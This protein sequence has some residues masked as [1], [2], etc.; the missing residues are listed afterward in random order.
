[1]EAVETRFRVM[2]SAAHVVVT[3]G[4]RGDLSRAEAT[5]RRLERLWS[6][7]LPDS[8]VSLL[9][10]ARGAAVKV[11]P[12]TVRLFETA[13]EGWS[14]TAGLFDPT[15]LPSVWSLGYRQSLDAGDNRVEALVDARMA[16]GFDAI[17]LDAR[18]STIRMAR[19]VGFDPG[20][21]G[22]GLAA[23]MA[24]EELMTSGAAGALVGVGGDL[25]TAGADP[26][27]DGWSV[28][29][30]DPSE[31][32]ADI[33]TLVLQEGGGVATS[34]AGHRR[35]MDA[36]DPVRHVIEPVTGLVADTDAESVTVV[37]ASA[38][39]AEVAATGALVAGVDQ[40]SELIARLGLE[41]VVVDSS[42]GVHY[43]PGLAVPA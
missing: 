42:H 6:R 4:S 12:E 41:S 5:L 26:D 11:H 8:D 38:W 29:I 7:F 21:I 18:R 3:G 19:D 30:E 2:G 16:P 33:A 24:V 22:K 37:A 23:D 9:N 39:M 1:M 15:V 25:R 32:A 27:G 10:R 35:W 13:R 28:A 36:D 40:G 34:T 14:R 17:I 43:S 20:A 31:A